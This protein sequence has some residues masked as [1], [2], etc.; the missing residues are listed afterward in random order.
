MRAILKFKVR[1]KRRNGSAV[2]H[3]LV[4]WAALTVGIGLMGSAMAL[5]GDTLKIEEAAETGDIN[6]CFTEFSG[7]GSIDMGNKTVDIAL[8]PVA[9]GYQATFDYEITNRGTVPVKV[10]TKN[11]SGSGEIVVTDT[12][13]SVDLDPGESDTGTLGI[14][15]A[16]GA[17]TGGYGFNLELVFKQWNAYDFSIGTP[18]NPWEESL[19]ITGSV[20]VSAPPP[21]PPP[22]SP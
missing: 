5:W 15:V 17:T 12:F 20:T 1:G 10:E 13:P 22:T 8:G 4:V 16:G 19:N 6:P 21:D 7:P 18:D 9:P 14:T 2:W 11:Y 3:G